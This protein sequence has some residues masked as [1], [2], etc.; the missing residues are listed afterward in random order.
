VLDTIREEFTDAIAVALAPTTEASFTAELKQ[1]VL[2]EAWSRR[3]EA[4]ALQKDPVSTGEV[5][6]GRLLIDRP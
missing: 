1:M 3:A 2:A 6:R 5:P 4:T